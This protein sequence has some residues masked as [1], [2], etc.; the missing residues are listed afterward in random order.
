MAKIITMNIRSIWT[1]VIIY[2]TDCKFLLDG[3]NV[4][5]GLYYINPDGRTPCFQVFCDMTNGGW[6]VIQQRVDDSVSFN[7]NW[8]E[9]EEGFG[10]PSGNFW[11]GLQ[12]MHSLTNSTYGTELVITV[13]TS[14]GAVYKAKYNFRVD[15]ADS[16][17]R[18]T[19][20]GFSGNASDAFTYHNGMS[21][22]T[23]DQDND[24]FSLHC[25]GIH[26]CGWWF[27]SCS[28][29]NLNS[30]FGCDMYWGPHSCLKS[31]SMKIRRTP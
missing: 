13:E 5:D 12:H 28:N 7:R 2:S 30:N 26:A 27:H 31:A 9:Y 1:K 24:P 14:D 23:S 8:A 20:D 15:D 16:K 25:A 29:C 6:T 19:V 3:G 21:F 11:A 17:Y 10:E 4:A 22:S 18:L